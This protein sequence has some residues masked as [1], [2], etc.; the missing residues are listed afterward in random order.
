MKVVYYR[1][2][3]SIIVSDTNYYILCIQ[4]DGSWFHTYMLIGLPLTLISSICIVIK[5]SACKK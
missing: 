4:T 5:H 1:Y 2:I 3:V